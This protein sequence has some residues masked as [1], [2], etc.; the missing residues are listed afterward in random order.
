MNP[1]AIYTATDFF[2]P[3]PSADDTFAVDVEMHSRFL[4]P[5]A[6]L[7]LS[8]LSSDLDGVIHFVQ[9]VE[10]YDGV[11]GDDSQGIFN[12]Y[13][14][15]NWVGLQYVDNQCKLLCDFNFF[16]LANLQSKASL[17][18]RQQQALDALREHYDDVHAGF[19]SAK[20][21]FALYGAL[22]SQRAKPPHKDSERLELLKSVGGQSEE[23]SCNWAALDDMPL[24]RHS[25]YHSV[26]QTE[27]GR[28]F[29][30]V[31]ELRTSHYVWSKRWALGC[32]LLLFYDPVTRVLLT[33]FDWS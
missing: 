10:P 4:L 20:E 22:H 8:R 11:V 28:D 21:H 24:S 32:E 15:L 7:H 33:T 9:P 13:C 17:S 2:E 18:K 27:D 14:R 19:N 30:F 31:G 12:H 25:D 29:I 5:L 23:H 3:F 26:P 1:N 16:Q 6:K